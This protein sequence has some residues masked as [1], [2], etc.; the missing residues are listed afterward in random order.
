M[1][2]QEWRKVGRVFRGASRLVGQE[3]TSYLDRVCKS[4]SELRHET[5]EL[6]TQHDRSSAFLGM[7]STRAEAQISHYKILGR[8]GEGAM[9]LVYKAED[10]KLKRLVAMKALPPWAAGDPSARAKIA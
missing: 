4:N 2:V 5:E 3:R 6:L 8:I 7:L 9:G 1:T 10:T